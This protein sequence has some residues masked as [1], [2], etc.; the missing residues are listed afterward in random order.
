[1]KWNIWLEGRI[2]VKAEEEKDNG[3]GFSIKIKL[4]ASRYY[5]VKVGHKDSKSDL[6]DYTIKVTDMT[7]VGDLNRAG[8]FNSIDFGYMRMYLLGLKKNFTYEELKIVDVDGNGSIN[9]VDFAI[10]R[11]VLIGM[12]DGF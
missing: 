6:D 8:T 1:M 5:Y 9:S 11:Q 2:I 10:M 7:A 12:R 3:E 4:G